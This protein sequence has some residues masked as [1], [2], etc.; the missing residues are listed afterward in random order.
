MWSKIDPRGHRIWIMK[1]RPCEWYSHSQNQSSAFFVED[2][3]IRELVDTHYFRTA[4]A[5]VVIR[6]TDKEGEVLI[7]T[8]KPAGV[9]GRDGANLAKFEKKL[10]KITRRPFKVTIK[11]VKVP[12]L[13]ARIMAEFACI[14]LENRM[15]YR[16]VAKSVLQKVMEKWAIGVKVQ[17]AWRLNG[18]EMSRNEKFTEW[19][20]PL[21][22][23][24]ADIDYHYSTAM[25]KYGVLGIKVWVCLSENMQAEKKSKKQSAMEKL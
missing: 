16:R 20:I 10:S 4:I 23:L 24:R 9:L 17:I 7:F 18:A 14:Q 3:K 1:D 8:A 22:T 21:Q 12:E 2:L 11:E 5:K 19:R 15:S 6:K 13:S 25:T